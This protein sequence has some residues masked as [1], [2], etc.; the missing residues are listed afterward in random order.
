MLLYTAEHTSCVN[1]DKRK[2]PAL[3]VHEFKKGESIEKDFFD[4]SIIFTLS[5]RCLI[6]FGREL[7]WELDS[8]KMVLFPPGSQALIRF[9][10]QTTLVVSRFED[11]IRLCECFPIEKLYSD[12]NAE[13][14]NLLTP[15]DIHT[16]IQDFFR[17]YIRQY[18]NGLKCMY[19]AELKNKEL[20]LLLRAYYKKEA[21][22][23]FFSPMLTPNARF[24]NFIYQNYRKVG[25]VNELIELSEYSV[26]GFK[27]QFQKTFGTS[28]SEWLR[29]QKVKHIYHEL[30]C[31]KLSI[32]ELCYKFDFASVS[33]FH[34]FC[35]SH[36]G[37][38]PG[39]IRKKL[40]SPQ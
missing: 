33:G 9:P 6:S 30:N 27:K 39:E 34:A 36:F 28:A 29:E 21:L 10:Q 32:K 14:Q 17:Q 4:T 24:S 38:P 11:S 8:R 22:A 13:K 18:Q 31:S 2:S 26:S 5:G 7:D 23:E 16:E 35:K 12:G 15:L 3:S 37:L 25:S 1:Y 40:Y 19:Y 20:F